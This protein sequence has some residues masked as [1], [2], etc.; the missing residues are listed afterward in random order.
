MCR[1]CALRLQELESIWAER[2]SVAQEAAAAQL[3][4]AMQ[5]HSLELAKAAET[6]A[7]Q[8]AEAEA[9]Y[10][11][12]VGHACRVVCAGGETDIRTSSSWQY[13]LMLGWDVEPGCPCCTQCL[14]P[15]SVLWCGVCCA[16]GGASSWM[17]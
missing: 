14:E 2:M 16:A 9:R 13:P 17:S 4:Q 1:T 15:S 7:L 3:N 5:R 12:H 6:A 10:G 11:C 8:A